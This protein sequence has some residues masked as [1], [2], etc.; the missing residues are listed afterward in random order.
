ML[1]RR[2]FVLSFCAIP[3][4]EFKKIPILL[5]HTVWHAIL[6]H[7]IIYVVNIADFFSRGKFFGGLPPSK[8]LRR[9]FSLL[10]NLLCSYNAQVVQL[11]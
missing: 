6:S 10:H 9:R 7:D 3:C 8:I 2:E 4:T 5:S 1:L 11:D